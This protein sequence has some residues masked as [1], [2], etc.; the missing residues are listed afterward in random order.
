MLELEEGEV[1]AS[2]DPIVAKNL[3]NKDIVHISKWLGMGLPIEDKT[4]KIY[5]HFPVIYLYWR[6]AYVVM[7]P[8]LDISITLG[9]RKL[10]H[11]PIDIPRDAT[12]NKFLMRL[13]PLYLAEARVRHHP[14]KDFQC[15]G[16]YR[17]DWF[18]FYLLPKKYDDLDESIIKVLIGD[19]PSR[20]GRGL[21]RVLWGG[22]GQDVPLSQFRTEDVQFLVAPCHGRVP[23][24][25]GHLREIISS[26]PSPLRYHRSV[27]GLVE[28]LRRCTLSLSNKNIP[29]REGFLQELDNV[30]NDPPLDDKYL[31]SF[32]DRIMGACSDE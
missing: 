9:T 10:W 5:N 20:L 22:T 14:V 21:R 1:I 17:H 13:V 8:G 31:S 29:M 11:L 12:P 28:R 6:I 7:P 32:I 3:I 30:P 4:F 27:D 15:N 2:G 23:T 18:N 24:P 16:Y 26:T 19:H 25:H